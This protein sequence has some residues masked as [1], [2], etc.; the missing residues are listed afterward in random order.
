MVKKELKKAMVC[1]KE[2]Q[3]RLAERKLVPQEPLYGV[4][5][6]LLDAQEDQVK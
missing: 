3:D 6:R 4:V 1:P 5:K 2:I